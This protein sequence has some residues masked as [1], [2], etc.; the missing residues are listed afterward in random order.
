MALSFPSLLADRLQ[1]AYV[2]SVSQ[3]RQ[4]ANALESQ[5]RR[6]LRLWSHTPPSFRAGGLIVALL[7]CAAM[8]A[9]F[10]A[11]YPP[12][13]VL[14]GPRLAAP[15]LSHLFGAD[16]LGRDLFSRV[17]HGSAIA[18]QA[19]ALGMGIAAALGIP[20]G[21]LAG[22][23]GGWLDQAFSRL[24][25][26]WLAFPGLLLALVVVARLGPSLQNAMLAVGALGAPGFYRLARS[27]TLSACR[28]AYVEAAQAVGC[29]AGRTLLRHILPNIAPSLVVFATMRAGMAILAVGGLSFVGLGAQP[30]SPE[31]GA[32]LATGRAHMDAAPWLAVFPGLCLTLAVVGLNLLG[33]GLRDLLDPRRCL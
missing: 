30:P 21:L 20:P 26:I 9:P 10:L 1:R 32:L 22:Y 33:D 12:D 13:Q 18:L 7:V 5:N 6:R 14:A 19:A 11:P 25:D 28:M 23:R 31:W 24:V 8:T 15:S 16:T 29:S 3:R 17:L 2:I 4:G 27:L